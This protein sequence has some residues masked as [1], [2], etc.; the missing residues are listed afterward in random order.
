MTKMFI[1]LELA[2]MRFVLRVYKRVKRMFVKPLE[3]KGLTVEQL[4]DSKEFRE[5]LDVQITME[6]KHHTEMSY[7]AVNA[8]LR[9]Q[10]APIQRLLDRD[11]QGLLVELAFLAADYDE[12]G[13]AYITRMVRDVGDR[14]VTPEEVSRCTAVIREEYSLRHMNDPA[15]ASDEDIQ[16]MMEA[17]RKRKQGN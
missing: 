14:I 2:V 12:A 4:I 9:L 13:M 5:E 15:S 10:R 11:R 16:A 8:G 1:R 7:Q 3:L 17:L 6:K